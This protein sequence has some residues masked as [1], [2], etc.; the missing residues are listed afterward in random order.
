MNKYIDYSLNITMF[1]PQLTICVIL[2]GVAVND[3]FLYQSKH[4][5]HFTVNLSRYI[6]MYVVG[7]VV[8]KGISFI[9]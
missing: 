3:E 5:E 2:F 7:C 9:G 6:F 8:M 4:H 1:V